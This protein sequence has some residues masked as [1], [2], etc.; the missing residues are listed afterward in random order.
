MKSGIRTVFKV[1]AVAFSCIW[2]P[3]AFAETEMTKTTLYADHPVFLDS[4]LGI[5]LG[6]PDFGL[7]VGLTP[8]Y[9]VGVRVNYVD[10]SSLSDRNASYYGAQFNTTWFKHGLTNDSLYLK[11]FLGYQRLTIGSSDKRVSE[12]YVNIM[13]LGGIVGYQWLWESGFNI[14]LGAGAQYYSANA[15]VSIQEDD[16]RAE[17]V[18][19]SGGILPSF[20]LT[21]GMMI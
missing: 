14:R 16:N 4:T 12:R 21:F 1:A 6:L 15:S 20:D 19:S 3:A 10:L 13:T 11:P 9:S 17:R 8:E 5:L 7:G 2:T 18:T